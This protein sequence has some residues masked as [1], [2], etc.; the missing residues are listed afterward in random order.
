MFTFRPS[1][2]LSLHFVLDTE[3]QRLSNLKNLL[4]ESLYRL[5]KYPADYNSIL[6]CLMDTI[7]IGSKGFGDQ[8]MV[9]V[10]EAIYSTW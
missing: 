2:S 9:Y 6:T 4:N 10:A 3:E 7:V 8:F 5:L 1:I